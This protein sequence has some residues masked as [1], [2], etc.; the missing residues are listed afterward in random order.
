[1]TDR[2]A[3][4][5]G[6]MIH[7]ALSESERPVIVPDPCYFGSREDPPS[8]PAGWVWRYFAYVDGFKLERDAPP[9]YQPDNFRGVDKNELW[10]SVKAASAKS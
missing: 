3:P 2:F 8:A 1:M 9:P 6:W 10:E 4:P 5:L 7:E